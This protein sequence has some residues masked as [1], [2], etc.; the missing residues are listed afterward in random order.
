M[1][2]QASVVGLPTGFEERTSSVELNIQASCWRGHNSPA[3]QQITI[4]G[5]SDEVRALCILEALRRAM[6]CFDIALADDLI[7]AFDEHSAFDY[8]DAVRHWPCQLL[9]LLAA[10]LIRA[11]RCAPRDGAAT[12]R[13]PEDPDL[14]SANITLARR[15]VRRPIRLSCVT[16]CLPLA[17]RGAFDHEVRLGGL[18]LL[19]LL[20]RL[21]SAAV[22]TPPAEHTQ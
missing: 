17:L 18:L 10:A 11:V 6:A 4:V 9:R 8:A 12:L 3:M 16:F 5:R 2:F 7:A 20:F 14:R 19:N 15:L 22:C 1:S 21:E 13:S